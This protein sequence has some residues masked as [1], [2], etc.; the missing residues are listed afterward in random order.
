MF[1]TTENLEATALTIDKNKEYY[2]VNVDS[3]FTSIRKIQF[4][5]IYP[6]FYGV[7][8]LN[9][10]ILKSFRGD[11]SKDGD[12]TRLHIK[13]IGELHTDFDRAIKSLRTQLETVFSYD[14]DNMTTRGV[15]SA[16]I[17]RRFGQ[18]MSDYFLSVNPTLLNK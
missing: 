16:E 5:K 12:S 11:A 7:G 6:E 18:A 17:D 10:K 4:D 3:T 15:I 1:D 9:F 13:N 8:R 14:N 2:I